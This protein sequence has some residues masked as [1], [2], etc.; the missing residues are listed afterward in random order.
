[1]SLE[2]NLNCLLGFATEI[3]ERPLKVCKF[4]D[5]L[6]QEKK[7]VLSKMGHFLISLTEPSS[8]MICEMSHITTFTPCSEDPNRLGDFS[9]VS[10]EDSN[11]YLEL[12]EVEWFC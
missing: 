6:G 11:P 7:A 10:S 4:I 1:M 8:P 5:T 9:D 3:G 2:E 12:E